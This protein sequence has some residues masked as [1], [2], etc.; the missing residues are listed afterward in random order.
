MAKAQTGDGAEFQR[1][2][3]ACPAFAAEFTAVGLRNIR[4][5]WGPINRREVE[6]RSECEAMLRRVQ[7][8]VDEFLEV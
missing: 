3:K 7:T 8:A 4:K 2:S 6:V 5:H 1:L